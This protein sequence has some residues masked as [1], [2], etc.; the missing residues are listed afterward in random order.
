MPVAVIL[1]LINR[2]M[3]ATGFYLP[4]KFIIKGLDIDEKVLVNFYY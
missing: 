3:L 4:L 2:F 1:L